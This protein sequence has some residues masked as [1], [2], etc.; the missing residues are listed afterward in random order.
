EHLIHTNETLARPGLL[1]VIVV[2]R[3]GEAQGVE[4]FRCSA[5]RSDAQNL[6]HEEKSTRFH[7][8]RL[9]AVR[10]AAAARPEISVSVVRESRATFPDS[11]MQEA[12]EKT[13]YFLVDE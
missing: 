1:P 11:P 6:E 3:H 10:N 2:N 13:H 4:M 9:V 8:R 5:V 12:P 7:G